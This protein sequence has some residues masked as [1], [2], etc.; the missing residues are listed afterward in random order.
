MTRQ[1]S[2]MASSPF[3]VATPI[4][5]QGSLFW[6]R[7]RCCARLTHRQLLMLPFDLLSRPRRSFV[8]SPRTPYS[9]SVRSPSGD[10][11]AG[12]KN[13]L[14]IA[15]SFGRQKEFVFFLYSFVWAIMLLYIVVV[16][17][18]MRGNRNSSSD[19]AHRPQLHVAAFCISE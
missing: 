12:E 16:T 3:L 2:E 14:Y 4:E 9:L 18:A 17:Y 13:R 8:V 19:R 11:G 10:D 15:V 7:P 1:M 6:Q 5:S